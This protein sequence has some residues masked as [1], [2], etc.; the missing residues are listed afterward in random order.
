MR[1]RIA[2]VI[3][4]AIGL[5]ACATT[6]GKKTEKVRYSRDH[7]NAAEIN[8]SNANNAHELVKALRPNWLRGVGAS[9]F[10]YNEV[11]YPI[12]Y[13]DKIKMGAM[14]NLASISTVNI[15]KIEHI[16]GSETALRFGQGHH[17]GIILITLK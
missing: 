13:V 10:K 11:A 4:L 14:D 7:I 1:F 17:G 15:L 5:S 2:T 16:K 6:D 9:S 12:V 3:L 8:T